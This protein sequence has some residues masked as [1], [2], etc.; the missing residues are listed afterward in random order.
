[1]R[2]SS[3]Q[4]SQNLSDFLVL[5]SSKWAYYRWLVGLLGAAIYTY[6][7]W[8]MEE[9][10]PGQT[11]VQLAFAFMVG[12]DAL[13]MLNLAN[14]F[15]RRI[16]I[17][18]LGLATRFLFKPDE[19]IPF[20]NITLIE[21]WRGGGKTIKF[22]IHQKIEQ[23]DLQIDSTTWNNVPFALQFIRSSGNI[24]LIDAGL[25]PGRKLFIRTVSILL[26]VLGIS[27]TWFNVFVMD[28]LGFIIIRFF[29]AQFLVDQ[30]PHDLKAIRLYLLIFALAVL[31]G[32]F[33]VAGQETLEIFSWWVY[34]PAIDITFSYLYE[35]VKTRNS[36]A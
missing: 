16:L 7:F 19:I 10:T 28:A 15:Y 6:F 27:F 12:L 21:C 2:F 17:D 8:G 30:K 1:M 3:T 13:L 9:I 36:T 11:P 4:N 32:L 29:W 14:S 25:N 31:F 5:K 35:K 24:P 23:L 34:S 33:L 20:E 22:Y 26:M 18:D